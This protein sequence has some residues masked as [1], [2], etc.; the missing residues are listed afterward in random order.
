MLRH[1]GRL[2]PELAA[3][4]EEIARRPERLRELYPR[5][6]AISIDHG[7]MEK[8]RSIATLPL[9][10]G[11]SDLGSWAALADV[12][13]KDDQGNAVSG[14][15]VAVDA[16]DNVLVADRGTVA[17][18]GVSGLVVVRTAD[19]VLVV[20]VERAQEVRSV[21]AELEARGRHEVSSV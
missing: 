21:I 2:Q 19:S 11:W 15:V 18:V 6:P 17:V 3:G 1:L 12:R 5:L 7:V 9:D 16:V 20:P 13:P 14:D 10:C 4:L 8:L